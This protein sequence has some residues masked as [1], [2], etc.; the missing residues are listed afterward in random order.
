MNWLQLVVS[1][2]MFA[3]ACNLDTVLLAMGYAAKGVQVGFLHSLIIAGVTTVVTW[4][5]L[6][7]GGAAA[8]VL[9]S[10]L[11][12][13]LGGL[14]LLGIG[15]WFVLDYLRYLGC[16]PKGGDPCR[17]GLWGCI[18]LGAA[19]AVNNAGIGVA[20]GVSGVSPHWAAV[21]NFTVTLAALPA[22]RWLGCRVVGR[23][24]GEYAL[25]LSGVLL[26]ILGAWKAFL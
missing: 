20:A 16:P 17:S 6:V 2:L 12:A 26:I 18:S 13:M 1:V 21:C 9:P 4:L 10:T 14:V 8:G 7:L 25:P 24:L 15:L 3:L 5:S 22:G 23:L 19:L 11:S